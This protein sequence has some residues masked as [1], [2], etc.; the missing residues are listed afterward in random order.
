M[1][2]GPAENALLPLLVGEQ[3]LLPANSL[4]ALNNNIARLIGPPIGGAILAVSGLS[5][6]VL[7]DSASFMI[8]GLMILAI[9]HL[10]LHAKP[11]ANT[12]QSD[13]EHAPP[14]H[15]WKEW[16]E[17]I[18][19]VRKN[20]VIGVLFVTVVLLNFGGIMIDPLGAPYMIE[21]VK[22]G[23]DVFGW[24]IT[25]Q[26]IGG[27]IGG[28]LVGK[29]N[30]K[31]S[32]AQLYGWAEL[33][34]GLFIFIRYNIP[35]LPVLFVMTFLLGLPA[36]LG[37]AALDTLFQQKVPNSYLGRII[38]ALNTTVGLTC[39]FGVLGISGILGE[40]LGMIPVLNIAAGITALTGLIVLLFLP[41]DQETKTSST[42][43]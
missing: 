16:K 39:L 33:I 14:S 18:D 43:S 38:G 22:V 2:F 29:L 9:G 34:L 24:L 10:T 36:A 37:S 28:L 42:S 41:A 35:Y 30:Q 6:V 4:N 1:F 20:R 26:A 32:I 40:R 5:G 12:T 21:I 8:A 11:F 13:T 27:M 31:L 19:I 3:E 23:P 15:F 17:G 25:V 7:F